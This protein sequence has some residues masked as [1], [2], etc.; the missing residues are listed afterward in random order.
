MVNLLKELKDAFTPD[1]L[2]LTAAVAAGK[3][4]IDLGYE[5]DKI[6]E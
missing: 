3:E 4:Q 6:Q 2:L 1:N 5:I